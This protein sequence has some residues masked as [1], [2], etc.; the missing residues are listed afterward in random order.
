M[1]TTI[2]LILLSCICALATA[3]SPVHSK[4]AV[5]E[6][7]GSHKPSFSYT[8]VRYDQDKKSGDPQLCLVNKVFPAS[9]SG[10]DQ[11]VKKILWH[12]GTGYPILIERENTAL[13][14][15]YVS[16]DERFRDFFTAAGEISGIPDLAANLK[17]KVIDEDAQG[18]THIKAIQFYRGI[19]VYGAEATLHLT[20][21][22][23]VFTG[24]LCPVKNGLSINPQV[25]PAQ[26]LDRAKTDLGTRTVLKDPTE[27]QKKLMP[28]PGPETELVVYCPDKGE[29]VLCYAVSLRPN[30]IESWKYFI[31]AENGEILFR[32]NETKSDGPASASAYDLNGILRSIETYL[33]NGTYYL[34]DVAEEMYNTTTGEGVILTLDANNTSTNN[35]SYSYI[36]SAD[37]NWNYPTAVSAHYNAIAT[38]RY[39]KNTFNRNSINDQGGDILSLIN[40]TE[41]DGSSMENAFWSGYAAFYGNGGSAFKP[42]AGA[43][44]VTAHELGHGVVG[45]TANLE[46]Y[47]QS[48]A[49]NES[50]ADIFGAMVDRDDWLIGEDVTR[51]SY[52]STGAL[53]DMSDPHNDNFNGWQPKHMSEIYLGEEDNAGVHTNSGIGN[54]AYYLFATAVSKEKA[55]QVFYRALVYYLTTK[56]Q[57]IDLRIAVIQAATD[58]Y[59]ESSAEVDEA[60]SAFDAVGILEEEPI[61]YTQDYNTNNG[62]N[63]LL[64]YDT[65]PL[66][67]SR[68]YRSS[69]LG[70]D[71]YDLS[72][73]KMKNRVSVV[74]DGSVGVFVSD[75]SK[76]RAFSTDPA[77]P[78]E[79]LLSDEAFWDNV[80]VSKDGNRL[81]CIS[82]Q[83]DTSIYVY[84]FVSERWARFQLYNPTTSNSGTDAGGVLYADAVMFDHTGE[85]LIYDAYNQL[86]SL[87]GDNIDY[88]DIGLIR[89]WDNELEDFG[90]GRIE[91][92]YGSLPQDVSIG[93]PVFSQNSPY[94]IAFD[95]WDSYT[96]EY[97]IFGVNLIS[98]ETDLIVTNTRLGYPAFSIQDNQLAYNAYTT[99]GDDIVAV[100]GLAANK[101]TSSGNPSGLIPDAIWPVYFATGTRDLV[102]APVA[103]FTVDLKSGEA[104]LEVRFIDLSINNP[105]GWNWIF[106]GGTPGSSAEQNPVVVY[107]N[108]GTFQVKLTCSNAAGSNSMTKTG[109]I[110][111]TKAAGVGNSSV[112]VLSFYPNPADEVLYIEGDQPF[113]IRIC[114]LNGT[115]IYEGENQNQIDVSSFRPGVYLLQFVTEERTITERLLIQ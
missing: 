57:Y 22:R 101:I 41:E 99:Q 77:A 34:Y 12:G 70:T 53:R 73:T 107:E 66:N 33:E 72:S 47:G 21:T 65:N 108:E 61:D 96:D 18:T 94:I 48:G 83:V 59:G 71:Y 29:P 113:R 87:T 49:I 1:K 43:L 54:Y 68:L 50:Y 63:Y 31:S 2:S 80:A 4:Q 40:V 86:E 16:P 9:L 102:L 110:S 103:S 79:V 51:T 23:E 25:T 74:D 64:S 82:T 106:E 3:Q 37:N 15:A 28:A 19:R 39:F 20:D 115:L 90:D 7:A 26:A 8:M 89:V 109:Y 85:Y 105:T 78:A 95:Y 46:Y 56:S 60:K 11:G 55:E 27:E 91:K 42:L 98:G 35:L 32:F 84:D 13:K 100:V 17:I 111:I 62:Q 76:I 6:A 104:P 52:I 38:Y 97:A 81:A 93:N 10:K 92:L 58:L 45:N 36:T 44:D 88:W 112:K 5:K 24:R 114:S 14:S 67:S 30:I 75:D 69:I